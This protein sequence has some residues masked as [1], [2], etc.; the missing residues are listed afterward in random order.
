[1]IGSGN[2]ELKEIFEKGEE[3]LKDEL[4]IIELIK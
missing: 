2:K 1:L 4:N 3:L